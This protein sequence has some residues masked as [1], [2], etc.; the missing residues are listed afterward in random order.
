MKNFVYSTQ[1][2]LDGPW[3]IDREALLHLG[4]SV[5]TISVKFDSANR[6]FVASTLIQRLERYSPDRRDE[7]REKC[8]EE[9]N[10]QYAMKRK[11][12]LSCS[13]S[14]YIEDESIERLLS[15]P[16]MLDESP[17]DIE[18]EIKTPHRS[19]QIKLGKRVFGG[20]KLSISTSPETDEL[21]REAFV[22]LQQWAAT[23]QVPLWQRF[24]ANNYGTIVWLWVCALFVIASLIIPSN[25]DYLEKELRPDVIQILK[26]GISN[27]EM[28]N[29]IELLLRNEFKVPKTEVQHPLPSWFKIYFFGGLAACLVL[30]FRPSLVIGVG[31]NEQRIKRWRWWAKFVG[32][33][34]PGFIFAS[35]ISPYILELL[36]FHQ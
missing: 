16:E 1:I 19:A 20:S 17:T 31:R 15:L 30:Y 4:K 21:A 6:E 2:T 9:V 18:V 22:D 28:P 3:L 33:T 34:L 11:V 36:G 14:K 13:G 8:L 25:T 12:T 27:D 26:N 10:Q 32:I 7:M 5:E 24:W 29:A 23:N 35:L